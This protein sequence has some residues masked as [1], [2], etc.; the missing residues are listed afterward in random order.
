MPRISVVDRRAELISAAL[1]VVAAEGVAAATT[2]AI[3]AEA[4]MSLAS[5]HY[6]FASRD[7]LL[8][9]LVAHVVEHERVV[10]DVGGLRTDEE[11]GQEHPPTLEAVVHA[12]L[13]RYVDLLR[14]DP[15]REAAMQELSAYAMRT[16]GLEHLALEQY[17]RYEELACEA[18]ALAAT[19]SGSTWTQPV[20]EIARTVIAFTDGLTL[21]WLVRRDDAEARRL[22]GTV[23]HLVATLA[24]PAPR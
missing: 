24:E 4:G 17:R 5:F 3:V 2:R 18:L 20:D 21:G 11:A 22:V 14:A 8:A 16:P 12:G 15:A 10:L 6:A 9:E 7:E 23:A 13:E 19:V 1:R